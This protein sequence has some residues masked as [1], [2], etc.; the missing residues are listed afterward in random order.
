MHKFLLL[1]VAVLSAQYASA[2]DFLVDR[3]AYTILSAADHTVSLTEA[4]SAT[5]FA[6]PATIADADGVSW[7]V[8]AVGENAFRGI[9]ALQTVALP[10]TVT[11]IGDGAFWSCSSLTAVQM[12]PRLTYLGKYAFFM[13]G[14]LAEIVIPE[15]VETI[16]E[17]AFDACS[18]L[19]KV[20][21]PS[22]CK[23][24]D[25]GAFLMCQCLETVEMPAALERIGDYAFCSC[26]NLRHITCAAA[27]PPTLSDSYA[28]DAT[29]FKK[30][31]VRVPEGSVDAYRAADVWKKFATFTATGID[32][33][34][35]YA[36]CPTPSYYTL[37]GQRVQQPRKGQLL[38][39]S[40]GRKIMY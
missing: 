19:R 10:E 38:I 36:Q 40:D 16:M 25:Y 34:T 8:V 22:T 32:A 17:T 20:S 31:E 7:T 1:F 30:A 37:Q 9:A 23:A 26:P 27:V 21:L 5:D 2:Y 33:P 4:P 39:A 3:A 24:V 15:G 11:S 6:V 14:K 29:V 28:F 18:S 35:P 12:P 13:C